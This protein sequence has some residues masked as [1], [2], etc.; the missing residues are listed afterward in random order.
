LRNAF[1]QGR[2]SQIETEISYGKRLFQLRIRDNG[3]GISA[4]ILEEGRA[5]HYG[6]LGMRERASRLGGKLEIW[7]AAKA[8]T[9][10]E[11]SIAGAIAYRTS[12]GRSLLRLFRREA[13]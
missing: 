12:P 13:G 4:S 2:A 11:L 7:S 5:G 8:G 10:I 3:K 9:E 1:I 6:L